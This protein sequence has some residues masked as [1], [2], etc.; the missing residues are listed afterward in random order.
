MFIFGWIQKWTKKITAVKKWPDTSLEISDGCIP[1]WLVLN[2]IEL[3]GKAA[4]STVVYS[5]V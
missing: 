2:P 1:D 3:Q 5:G 4:A